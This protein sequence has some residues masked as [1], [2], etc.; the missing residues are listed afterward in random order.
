VGAEAGLYQVVGNEIRL[1]Q[2]SASSISDSEGKV[3]Y[4]GQQEI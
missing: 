4:P 2:I 1:D 3:M